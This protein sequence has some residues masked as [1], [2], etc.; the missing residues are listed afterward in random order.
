MV[1]K[2][3]HNVEQNVIIKV[4]VSSSEQTVS[5]NQ[6]DVGIVTKRELSKLKEEKEISQRE[7]RI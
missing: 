3:T 2:L 1:Y 5:S 6:V 4:D 7:A